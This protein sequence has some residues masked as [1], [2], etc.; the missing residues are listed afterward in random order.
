M[1]VLL[2]VLMLALPQPRA[3]DRAVFVL[4]IYGPIGPA[5]K[6]YMVRGMDRAEAEGASLVVLRMDTPGGLDASMRDMI[7][8]ILNAQV[9][10]ATWVGPPGARAAS[11]GTFILYASHVA[12]MAPSTNLGAA[13][14]VQIG[15]GGGGEDQGPRPQ[16]GTMERIREAIAADENDRGASDRASGDAASEQG[17][18]AA[19]SDAAG[20]DE[21][22]AAVEEEEAPPLRGTATERKVMED[23][24]A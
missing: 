8:R 1:L 5:I 9:P 13:S 21:D 18:E 23:A 2:G 4:D 24:V 3:S 10:V 11:A 20:E 12:A 19:P 15:G 6:D 17:D 22:T 16:R 7:S 14:P